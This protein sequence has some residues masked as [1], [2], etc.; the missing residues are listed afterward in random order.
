MEPF[1]GDLVHFVGNR[2]IPVSSQAVDADPDQEMSSDLLC[3]AEKLVDVTLAITDMDAAS[4]MI[5]ELRRLLESF[6][7]PDAFFFLRE[8][9]SD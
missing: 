2:V 5:Q 3:C 6:Q 7:P 1:D 4:G 9:G 8:S